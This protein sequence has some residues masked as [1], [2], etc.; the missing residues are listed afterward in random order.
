VLLTFFRQ[1]PPEDFAPF[2]W[3]IPTF[4]FPTDFSTLLFLSHPPGSLDGSLSLIFL[5]W[6]SSTR[7][8]FTVHRY[9][10]PPSSPVAFAL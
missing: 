7:V 8:F 9:S 10:S 5:V 3:C 6:F 4:L 2:H 1:F